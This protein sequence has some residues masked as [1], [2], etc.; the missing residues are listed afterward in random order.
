MDILD[1]AGQEEYSAM[2]DSYMRSGQGFILTYAIT[3]R[4]SFDELQEFHDQILRVKDADKVPM[5]L[6]GNKCDMEEHR[7][8]TV[9]EGQTIAQQW[10]IPFFETSAYT[11]CNVD[12]AFT[13]LAREIKKSL[14]PKDEKSRKSRG[15]LRSK[16]SIL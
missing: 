8:V 4:T 7:Q 13:D 14:S 9:H 11:R 6:V 15:K 10:G 12:E 1:T 5:V 2:R 16:C 3:S